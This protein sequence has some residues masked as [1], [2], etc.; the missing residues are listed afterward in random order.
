MNDVRKFIFGAIIGLFVFVGLMIGIVYVSACGLTFTCDRADPKLNL[1]PIPTLIPQSEAQVQHPSQSMTEFNKCQVNAVD[2]I[3]AWVTAG[4]PDTEPFPFTSL[5]GESCEGTY[6]AD[7][8]HLF[9]ENELWKTGA[10]GCVSCHNADFTDRS[11]GLDLTSYDSVLLGSRRVAGSS[12]KGNEILGNGDWEKSVLYDV[13]ANQ[14]LVPEGHSADAPAGELILF[15][16][17]KII[18]PAA[19]ATVKP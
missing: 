6:S 1:T 7:I 11:S 2:L 16:G 17:Q 15:A 13:L 10:I 4:T 12:S 3:G 14:A 9:V 18:E 8:Q 19:T 5:S